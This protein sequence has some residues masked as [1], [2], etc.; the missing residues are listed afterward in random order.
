M[1]PIDVTFSSSNLNLAG[2]LYIP[3]SYQEGERLPAIVVN[4]PGG[5]VKE[6]TAGVYAAELSKQGFIA[7]AFDRRS[8]GA[9]EGTPRCVEDPFASVEDIKSAVTYLT[10]NNK[11]DPKRIGVFG[12][13]AGGGYSVATASTDSRVKAVATV[14]M[15]D[16]GLLFA[17]SLP[18]ETLASLIAQAGENRTEYAKG[19]EVKYLPYIPPDVNEDSLVLMK[20]AYDYYLTPRGSHCRSVNKFALW[21]YDTLVA[22]DSFAKIE[23]IAPRPMLLIAG[24]DADTLEHSRIALAKAGG[25]NKELYTIAGASHIDLYD[26]RVADCLPKLIEFFKKNL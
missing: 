15:V 6:Q 25:P 8:Q 2:H 17:G 16:I 14:S 5:G 7:L 3:S 11:V 20:E 18:E 19:G 10:T 21:S 1:A 22:Y 24:T 9:S 23:R 13:C 12:V 4:H 26:K